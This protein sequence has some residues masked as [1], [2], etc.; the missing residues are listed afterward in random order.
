MLR[1]IIIDSHLSQD[2][3][4]DSGPESGSL[5]RSDPS[6]DP[7][8][9]KSVENAEELIGKLQ[10]SALITF[11]CASRRMM[12]V[13]FDPRLRPKEMSFIEW[14]RSCAEQLKKEHNDEKYSSVWDEVLHSISG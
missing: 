10:N 4:P 6:E 12:E 14:I 8:C 5:L 3:G 13:V 1:Y 2:F 7:W 11:V 9:F